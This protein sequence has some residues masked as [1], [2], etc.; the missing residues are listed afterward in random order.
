MEAIVKAKPEAAKGTY[1]KSCV[2]SSTMGVGVAVATS[3][4]GA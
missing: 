4:F 3:K 1:I 2:V